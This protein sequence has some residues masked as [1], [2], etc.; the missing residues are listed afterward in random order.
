M[1][2]I[3]V[4]ENVCVDDYIASTNIVMSVFLPNQNAL[5]MSPLF[6]RDSDSVGIPPVNSSGAH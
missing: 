6:I 3:C 1:H 4:G 2:T 5:E